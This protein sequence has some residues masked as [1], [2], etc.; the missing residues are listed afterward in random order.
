M[1]FEFAEVYR[2]SIHKSFFG[3]DTS[4]KISQL[5]MKPFNQ[6][7]AYQI[8][9]S[10]KEIEDECGELTRKARSRALKVDDYLDVQDI[11]GD[12][13][14]GQIKEIKKR[15]DEFY[16]RIQIRYEKQDIS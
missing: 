7:Y 16:Y 14:Y 15:L 1:Q 11:Q 9:K 12:W 3:I 13:R 2:N 10:P 6:I 4:T 8:L 5:G